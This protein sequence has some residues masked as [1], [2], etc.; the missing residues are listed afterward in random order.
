MDSVVGRGEAMKRR[1]IGRR[2]TSHPVKIMLV[3]EWAAPGLPQPHTGKHTVKN[4]LSSNAE[5]IGVLR[6]K[7]SNHF[8][9]FSVN[10]NEI[11]KI[12]H[13]FT[14]IK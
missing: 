14:K 4:D 8:I 9:E 2:V 13:N 7:F 10:N 11:T 5:E 6:S 1:N 12:K 3:G